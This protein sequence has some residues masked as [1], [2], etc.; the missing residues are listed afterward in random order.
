MRAHD[1]ELRQAGLRSLSL[2]GS[3]ARGETEM[4]SDIDLA[5]EFDPGARM[6]P[7]S[8]SVLVAFPIGRAQARMAARHQK[9]FARCIKWPLIKEVLLPITY[10]RQRP[11]C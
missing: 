6:D 2:F 9:A 8:A 3:L 1:E 5:A 7:D 4:D 11:V 10:L